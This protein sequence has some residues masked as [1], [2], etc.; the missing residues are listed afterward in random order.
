V[1]PLFHVQLDTIGLFK[2]AVL[3][4]DLDLNYVVKQL[5]ESG[6]NGVTLSCSASDPSVA[7]ELVAPLVAVATQ[8]K[9]GAFHLE[10]GADENIVRVAEALKPSR[11][12][13]QRSSRLEF[14]FSQSFAK[15]GE[16]EQL[17]MT[18]SEFRKMHIPVGVLIDAS[19]E[20]VEAVNE[21]NAQ[22]VEI[23]TSPLAIALCKESDGVDARTR[24]TF[25]RCADRARHFYLPVY[26]GRGVSLAT[27]DEVLKEVKPSCL[28]VGAGFA[29]DML[30]HGII[31]ATQL[32][33]ARCALASS[34]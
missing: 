20:N 22:F 2:K 8:H 9:D 6:A 29:V 7:S 26:A 16:I 19:E 24:T 33:A 4:G 11:V 23:E 25:S 18:V 27:I 28:T 31:G 3:G 10:G 12:T 32:Y 17:R 21:V 13:L 14:G 1:R 15:P 34:K 5:F 30:W